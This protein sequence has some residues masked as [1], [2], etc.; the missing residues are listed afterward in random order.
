M[1]KAN[2]WGREFELEVIYDCY[3]GEDVLP[4]QKEA[5][6]TFSKNSELLSA[7]K[8]NIEQYCLEK[9]KEEIGADQVDN[10]FK[11]VLPE[12]IFIKRDGRIAL[13][14]RYKF[15]DHGIAIVFKNKKIAEIGTRDII[16]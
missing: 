8:S 11:Y 2:I 5:F 13:M 9:N 3:E 7:S 12:C 16:L 10:I 15:D 1:Y 14:C 4:L 6:E